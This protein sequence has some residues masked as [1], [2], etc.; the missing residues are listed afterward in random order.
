MSQRDAA[1]IAN[2]YNYFLAVAIIR[3]GETNPRGNRYYYAK[4]VGQW[5][6]SYWQ[7]KTPQI[8][9]YTDNSARARAQQDFYAINGQTGTAKLEPRS[10]VCPVCEGWI[11]RGLVPARVALNNPPPY[12]VNCPHVWDMRPDTTHPF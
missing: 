1:S 3:A 6:V 8:T 11:K 12:H 10:A 9:E 2:T 5:D 7:Y 4:A